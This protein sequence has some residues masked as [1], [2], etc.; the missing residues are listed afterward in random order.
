MFTETYTYQFKG[1]QKVVQ[2]TFTES[3]PSIPQGYITI[4]DNGTFSLSC[5]EGLTFT[6]AL[7]RDAMLTH[8]QFQKKRKI[9]ISKLKEAYEDKESFSI[10]ASAPKI[11][12]WTCVTI[13]E[14]VEKQNSQINKE[15]SE[16]EQKISSLPQV[17]YKR[18]PLSVTEISMDEIKESLIDEAKSK[19][20]KFGIWKA[21]QN[22][23]SI[24][25]S[26]H[27]PIVFEEW[28]EAWN[29]AV[30]FSNAIENFKEVEE[31]QKLNKLRNI[32]IK[33]LEN[34]IQQKLTQ[35][36]SYSTILNSYIKLFWNTLNQAVKAYRGA[37][38]FIVNAK[39]NLDE[40]LAILDIKVPSLVECPLQTK[41]AKIN[42][43][44]IEV[45]KLNEIA[46]EK[47]FYRKI[48]EIAFMLVSYLLEAVN[49]LSI[50]KVKVLIENTNQGI[51]SCFF[52]R[53]DLKDFTIT[54][55]NN[56]DCFLPY[57]IMGPKTTQK[58]KCE[59]ITLI[60]VQEQDLINKILSRTDL[61]NTF[62]IGIE[63][64]ESLMEELEKNKNNLVLD[65]LREVVNE[66][67]NQG[68]SSVR[69]N[70]KIQ[71]ILQELN[72]IKR[73]TVQND[74]KDC[75]L[76]GSSFSSN[77]GKSTNI[78]S[79]FKMWQAN[80]KDV[81][82][83]RGVTQTGPLYVRFT[84]LAAKTRYPISLLSKYNL[85]DKIGTHLTI[86]TSTLQAIEKERFALEYTKYLEELSQK[87]IN[88]AYSSDSE[89][90]K[91][92]AISELEHCVACGCE[93]LGVYTTLENLY[94]QRG[95]FQAL[96]RIADL[97]KKIQWS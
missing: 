20:M 19:F 55:D 27:L 49:P 50:I 72:S 85:L 41:F 31:L 9:L 11:S 47:L 67:K 97:H 13:K 69:L 23:I 64:A 30:T 57:I 7:A 48:M 17:E 93:D 56:L 78:L 82:S 62:P 87:A 14:I 80:Q 77:N 25:V 15:L 95:E 24:Y 38:P 89:W 84:A 79:Y 8:P 4:K 46:K 54:N 91:T 37:I 6:Q 74:I 60:D 35:K 76:L 83:L 73:Q 12:Q 70:K 10:A 96:E 22:K 33:E 18:N 32:K 86:T 44:E 71:P 81:L 90:V 75:T 45:Y 42:G 59:N 1:S 28:K 21:P 58:Q 92:R 5:K 66:A 36:V 26:E 39:C 52:Y 43:S 61:Q 3:I 2:Y 40:G 34:K 51:C 63:H 16:L 65:E 94:K 68:L 29:E 88:M 53:S